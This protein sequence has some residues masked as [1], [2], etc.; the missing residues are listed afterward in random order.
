LKVEVFISSLITGMEDVR[1]SAAR[2]IEALGHT[3]VRA[4][5]F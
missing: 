1:A 2:A 5:A 3:L 4:E